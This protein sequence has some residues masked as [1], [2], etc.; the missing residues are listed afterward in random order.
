MEPKTL[1]IGQMA[2]LLGVSQDFLR[3]NRG[4]LFI[5]GVHYNRPP[6]LNKDLWVV[7]AMQEWATGQMKI[8]QTAQQ[9]LDRLI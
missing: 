9:V 7:E 6:G 8:S 4:S 5:E 2:K 3:K 1:S